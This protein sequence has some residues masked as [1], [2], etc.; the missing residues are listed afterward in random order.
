MLLLLSEFTSEECER[1]AFLKL[2]L[3]QV[4][5]VGTPHQKFVIPEVFKNSCPFEIHCE[6]GKL[7]WGEKILP[8]KALPLPGV[9]ET[10]RRRAVPPAAELR[11]GASPALTK[12]S[13]PAPAGAAWGG[14]PT[15]SSPCWGKKGRLRAFVP[16]VQNSGGSCLGRRECIS[17]DLRRCPLTR[18]ESLKARLPGG[19][20]TRV[21]IVPEAGT[22]PPCA[23]G[24]AWGFLKP[25]GWN[26]ISIWV[27]S[28]R[29]QFNAL[30]G[31]TRLYH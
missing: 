28:D 24:R 11:R 20:G 3:N 9:G 16:E 15:A 26:R 14:R 17:S 21:P 18:Y 6:G 2:Y 30:Q 12:L 22:V 13:P 23:P 7:S 5:E 8:L 19:H 1:W 27:G 10:T 29:T 4:L 31:Q 25:L